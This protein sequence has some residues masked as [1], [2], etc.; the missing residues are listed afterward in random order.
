MRGVRR[1]RAAGRGRHESGES[2]G[3]R[4]SDLL[5][6]FTAITH[7]RA[8]VNGTGQIGVLVAAS[9]DIT[10]STFSVPYAPDEVPRRT[11]EA[12]SIDARSI[13]TSNDKRPTKSI[14]VTNQT[15]CRTP[16]RK[17]ETKCYKDT[18]AKTMPGSY[19]HQSLKPTCCLA[20]YRRCRNT[21]Y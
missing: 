21:R 9:Q 20:K 10:D 2:R 18:Q 12:R 13:D 16:A 14:G 11:V 7:L 19:S 17:H 3:T 4:C 1:P 15:R 8:A 5:L 6:H